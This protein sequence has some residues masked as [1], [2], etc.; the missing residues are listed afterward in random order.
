MVHWWNHPKQVTNHAIKLGWTCHTQLQGAAMLKFKGFAILLLSFSAACASP[1]A[2]QKSTGIVLQPMSM[3]EA[4]QWLK[5]EGFSLI[6]VE[7]TTD[8]RLDLRSRS[9]T[10][11]RHTILDAASFEIIDDTMT[12][13]PVRAATSD[14]SRDDDAGQNN[15]AAPTPI[16]ASVATQASTGSPHSASAS[17]TATGSNSSVTASSSAST[18]QGSAA[19]ATAE[20]STNRTTTKQTTVS[21]NGRTVTTGTFTSKSSGTAS[22]SVTQ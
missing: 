21:E 3:S 22:S 8:G 12:P 6:T 16:P 9:N 10:H 7:R 19:R 14:S 18:D 20:A 2:V 15:E 11:D 4:V 5:N 13:L 17:A 1:P